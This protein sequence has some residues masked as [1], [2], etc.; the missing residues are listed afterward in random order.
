MKKKLLAILAT[1]VAV[2]PL[3]AVKADIQYTLGSEHNFIVNEEQYKTHN[4]T[5][6][7]QEERDSVGIKVVALGEKTEDG[8]VK[9]LATGAVSMIGGSPTEFAS[10][11]EEKTYKE[12]RNY[13]HMYDDLNG[14]NTK[15]LDV[16]STSGFPKISLTTDY[17]KNYNEDEK[18]VDIMSAKD[19]LTWM[20][21][22]DE[23]PVSG[24]TYSLTDAELTKFNTWFY[25]TFLL[26]GEY[27]SLSPGTTIGG[28]YTKDFDATT[29]KIWTVDITYADGKVT[30][31]VLK[32]HVP[33]DFA[34][35]QHYITIPI[36]YFNEIY[37]CKYDKVEKTACY[38]CGDEYQWLVVGSQAS[39]CEAVSSVTSKAKC[40]KPSETGVEDYILE[41]AIAA[42]ICGLVL[43]A[44]KRKSLFSRV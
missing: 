23:T 20:K 35:S 44:V 43:V 24:S 1:F 8:Y 10:D 22:T 33:T 28:L 39:T 36:L 21:G 5:A 37:D 2:T 13:L 3:A 7:S 11:W 14:G 12:L 30:S 40:V 4:N 19:F 42:G 27:T 15:K 32:E 6:L 26:T 25:Y 17:V 18:W 9:A 38:K 41:F 34:T 29:G 31:A 16:P